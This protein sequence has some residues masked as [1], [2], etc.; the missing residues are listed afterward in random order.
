MSNIDRQTDFGLDVK[1]QEEHEFQISDLCKLRT[2]S[3]LYKATHVRHDGIFVQQAP[4]P[5][6]A[7]W[8]EQW[9]TESLG[10]YLGQVRIASEENRGV[11]TKLMFYQKFMFDGQV[12]YMSA[13]SACEMLEIIK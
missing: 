11:T 1:S 4:S 6:A 7:R 2:E 8:M 9:K 3:A 5:A 13:D 12:I 10:I